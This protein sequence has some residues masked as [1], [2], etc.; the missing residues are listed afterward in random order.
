MINLGQ[1]RLR[2]IS[3]IS[4][5]IFVG[6][7]FGIV[8]DKS[9]LSDLEMMYIQHLKAE[10]QMLKQEKEE[11]ITY[12]ENELNQ[13]KLYTNIEKQ[14]NNDLQELFSSIGLTVEAIPDSLNRVGESEGIIISI[15]EEIHDAYGLPHLV[16]DEIPKGEIDLNILYV[17]LLKMKEELV[18]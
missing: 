1:N 8:M 7:I 4:L 3:I 5:S 12:V 9:W 14:E 13:V 11:W 18:E 17:S 16:I 2:L 15:G 6:F 10:Q